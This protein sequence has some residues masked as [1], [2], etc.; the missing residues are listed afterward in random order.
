M[1][2][3]IIQVSIQVAYAFEFLSE[4]PVSDSSVKACPGVC[5]AERIADY[6]DAILTTENLCK[7]GLRCCVSRDAFGEKPPPYLII[8]NKTKNVSRPE[9]QQPQQTTQR[10]SAATTEA[11][12]K[13]PF[14]PR[15]TVSKLKRCPGECV[16]GLFALFCDD[17]D[18]EA[19]CPGEGSCCTTGSPVSFCGDFMS[20][21]DQRLSVLVRR[22]GQPCP[23]YH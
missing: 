4:S 15:P 8:P 16:S 20:T 2:R 19:H 6:C 17:I 9:T 13:T 10:T 3:R 11:A 7:V 23:C 14:P 21:G 18:S 22:R 1:R 5:V 12:L